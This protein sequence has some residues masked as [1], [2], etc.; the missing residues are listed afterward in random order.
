MIVQV[1]CLEVTVE[2][3][4][5]ISLSQSIIITVLIK[6][7][8]VKILETLINTFSKNKVNAFYAIAK[9]KTFNRSRC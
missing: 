6:D 8:N 7:T 2:N 9:N 5:N 4:T 3:V 1:S